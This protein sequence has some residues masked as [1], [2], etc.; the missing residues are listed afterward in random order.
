M[1]NALYALQGLAH[2]TLSAG[3]LARV[4][5]EQDH[6]SSHVIARNRS[7]PFDWIHEPGRRRRN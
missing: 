6:F 5:R 1:G 7:K 4:W 2:P 3:Q